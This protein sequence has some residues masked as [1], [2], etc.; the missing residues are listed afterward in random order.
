MLDITKI[1]AAGVTH[2]ASDV[3]IN[4]GMPPVIRRN[5]ELIDMDLPAVSNKE[6]KEMIISMVGED[7]FKQFLDQRDLDFSTTKPN[8]EMLI[9]K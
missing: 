4:V 7:R 1:L 8:Q 6:A 5:T 3:H 9:M 2:Q